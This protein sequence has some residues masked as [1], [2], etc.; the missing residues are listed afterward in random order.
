MENVI[1]T[2]NKSRKSGWTTLLLSIFLGVFG[3]HRFYV[4]KIGTG[5]LMIITLGGLGIWLF[6][7][8]IFIVSNKFEDK[9][10]NNIVLMQEPSP[11]K[12]GII[13]FFAVFCTILVYLGL[14]FAIVLYSTSGLV[15][16]IQNQL[17]A[18][19]HGNMQM[20]Y[21]YTSTGFQQ[22]VSFEHFKKVI[23]NFSALKN[24]ASFSWS[25]REFQ[26]DKGFVRAILK[27]KD[28]VILPIEYRLIKED[29]QW[30]I[31][32][33]DLNPN[34]TEGQPEVKSKPLISVTSEKMNDADSSPSQAYRVYEDKK[35]KF[36]IKYPT[37]WDISS[38]KPGQLFITGKKGTASY[39]S[40]V[41][42]RTI[43]AKKIGGKFSSAKAY[44]VEFKTQMAKKFSN[45]KFL[46]E[47]EAELPQNPKQF[48]GEY[49]MFTFTHRNIA[50]KRMDFVIERNDGLAFYDWSYTSPAKQFD[51]DLPLAKT[52]YE[53][54]VIK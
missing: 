45:V 30:K 18:I 23:N 7:D 16:P 22:T 5:L 24:N 39:Y 32:G 48:H 52:M 4:G 37:A 9:Q 51:Q 2:V 14:F 42:I 29:G 44:I 31:L 25:K 28:G 3:A 1:T 47:G 10:G 46:N 35:A 50:L 53:S 12:K 40:F 26:N 38:K 54:W 20:A 21:S 43:P 49:V 36:S 17:N 41:T 27:S 13:G 19:Q 11:W 34:N 15:K 6:T 8:L 33:F